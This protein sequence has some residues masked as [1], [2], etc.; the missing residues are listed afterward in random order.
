MSASYKLVLQL[1]SP[2]ADDYGE[3]PEC[4]DLLGTYILSSHPT[5]CL[6]QY[7]GSVALCAALHA[8]ESLYIGATFGV[9]A[10]VSYISVQ[11]GLYYSSDCTPP[12]ATQWNFYYENP[13]GLIDCTNLSDL[14]IPYS[15]GDT[16]F[17]DLSSSQ[18]LLTSL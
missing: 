12:L 11:I 13:S 3:C 8:V 15:S 17:C 6:V 2:G 9:S 7:C 16:L 18:L 10:G 14:V 1:V 5:D 4:P